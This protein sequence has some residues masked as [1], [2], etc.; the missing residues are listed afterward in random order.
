MNDEVE[1]LNSLEI[2]SCRLVTS[3]DDLRSGVV[4]C[5]LV[6]YLKSRNFFEDVQR[7][8]SVQKNFKRA[9]INNFKIFIREIGARLPPSLLRTPEEL[10]EDVEILL[11]IV[12]YLKKLITKPL[13]TERVS[14]N[15]TPRVRASASPA[16]T[17]RLQHSPSMLDIHIAH[18]SSQVQTHDK[19]KTW[20]QELKLIKFDV[21]EEMKDGVVLCELINRLEG[22]NE[23]IKGMHKAPKT[24]SAIQVNINKALNYLRGIEKLNS[25]YL[26]S[27]NEIIQGDEETIFGLL[28]SIQ[29]FYSIKR[30]A[31]ASRSAK[32]LTSRVFS[33]ISFEGKVEP[34]A[35]PDKPEPEPLSAR[36]WIQNIGLGKYL[37]NDKKHFLDD[38]C[39]NGVLLA[40]VLGKL[41]GLEVPGIFNPKSAVSASSNYEKC[42]K[43]IYERHPS[44]AVRYL[45]EIDRFLESDLLLWR[46]IEELISIPRN[47][48][49]PN[50]HLPYTREEISQLESS[51]VTWLSSLIGRSFEGFEEILTEISTLLA[52][53]IQKCGFSVTGVTKNPKTGKVKQGNIEKSLECLR[54]ISR[55][56]QKFLFKVEELAEGNFLVALGL[57]EDI[58]RFYD[59]LPAR[60]RGPHYHSDGPYLGKKSRVS[61][62]RNISS[63]LNK[64]YESPKTCCSSKRIRE[65]FIPRQKFLN[66]DH[67]HSSNEFDWVFSLGLSIN[68]LDLMAEEIEEFSSGVLL[69]QIIDKLERKEVT[70]FQIKP[71]GNAGFLFN[72]GKA[73]KVLKEKPNFPSSLMFVDEDVVK[74]KGE[75]IRELLRAVFKIYRQAIKTQIKFYNPDKVNLTFV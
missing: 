23:V 33:N 51:L 43:F 55:M 13:N 63:L 12:K 53:I 57:L 34:E 70:G 26:W 22:R 58:H 2:N 66:F 61:P 62:L 32:V 50:T 56:S 16:L 46:L 73:L 10:F 20:L 6:A 59:G 40:E 47:V 37:L 31:S 54:R 45:R 3:A 17:S 75:A 44:V 29:D 36:A 15:L 67:V 65:D 42:L 28:Q 49:K 4:L 19:L 41:E 8:G 48:V 38:P 69:C 7:H 21:I 74:G 5:D 71:K 35:V 18:N 24:K 14:R 60:K 64:S 11:E 27:S 68:S 1:W 39:R 72:V 25:K 30:S 52:E 9:A